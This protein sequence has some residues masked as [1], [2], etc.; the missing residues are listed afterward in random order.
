MTN[1]KAIIHLKRGIQLKAKAP[2]LA[3]LKGRPKKRRIRKTTEERP[4]KK[5]RCSHCEQL[6][7]N[8]KGCR[9]RRK[10][11][12]VVSVNSEESEEEGIEETS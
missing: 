4:S 5:Y 2:K 12:E 7:H 3:Q 1:T 9:N 10:E 6:G 8:R 11:L